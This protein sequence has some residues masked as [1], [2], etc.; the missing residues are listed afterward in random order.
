MFANSRLCNHFEKSKN[1]TLEAITSKSARLFFS[2]SFLIQHLKPEE[3]KKTIYLENQLL[4]NA[5]QAIRLA[6][7]IFYFFFKWI[8]L[9]ET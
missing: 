1:S 3:N 6:T 8:P 4:L 9:K 5:K 2:H 7:L